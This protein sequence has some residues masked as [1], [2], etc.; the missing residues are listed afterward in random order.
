MKIKDLLHK[1]RDCKIMILNHYGDEIGMCDMI[2]LIR[3]DGKDKPL[4]EEEIKTI[5]MGTED[6]YSGY[7]I[8]TTIA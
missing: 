3:G 4:E 5:T 7:I 6:Y 2:D 1:C 8:V